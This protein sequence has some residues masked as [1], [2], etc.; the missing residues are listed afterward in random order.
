MFEH[1]CVVSYTSRGVYLQLQLID[2]DLFTADWGIPLNYESSKYKYNK[3][4]HG[5]Y[6]RP[7]NISVLHTMTVLCYNTLTV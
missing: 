3:Y 6:P 5:A 2:G 4:F 7:P 1:V